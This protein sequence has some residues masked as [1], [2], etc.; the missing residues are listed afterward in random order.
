M[1][2]GPNE[3]LEDY[4][5]I[6]Q[7][8]YRVNYNLNRESLKLV[9]PQGIKE[10]IMETLN[11]PSRGDIYQLTYDEIN[12]VFKNHSR[13]TVKKGRSIQRFTNSSSSTSTIKHEIRSMLEDFK[14]EIFH[15]FSL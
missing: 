4:E 3:S 10:D 12:T 11:M 7:L 2:L 13:V 1:T 15:T 6:F 8:N 9:L 14:S 5:E